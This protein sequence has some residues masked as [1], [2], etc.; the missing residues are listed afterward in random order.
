MRVCAVLA[1]TPYGALEAVA[2]HMPA[3][4]SLSVVGDLSHDLVERLQPEPKE[5]QLV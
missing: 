5:L 4:A 1:G 2:L 3:E